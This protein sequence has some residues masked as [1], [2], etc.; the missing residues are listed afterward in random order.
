MQ[1]LGYTDAD[2]QTRSKSD[3][4][5]T[6][7]TALSREN[8]ASLIHV[9]SPHGARMSQCHEIGLKFHT[10]DVCTNRR[11]ACSFS[12]SRQVSKR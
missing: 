10:A 8:N 12:D 6:S 4:L 11:S 1:P 7:I 3:T 2:C 9:P 5:R